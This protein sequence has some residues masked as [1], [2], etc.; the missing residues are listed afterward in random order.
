MGRGAEAAADWKEELAAR[1]TAHDDWFGY[2]ELCLFP[3]GRSRIPPRPVATCW[4]SSARPP[5]HSSPSG[6]AGA[7]LLLRQRR[8]G[9][10][11]GGRLTER[12]VDA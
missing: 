6:W 12:A 9:T 5:T 10:N 8:R 4:R 11:S 2:A 1:P 3:G 7:C